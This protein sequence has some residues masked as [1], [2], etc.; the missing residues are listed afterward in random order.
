MKKMK[1][2]IMCVLMLSFSNVN[3]Q[4]RNFIVSGIERFF[5]QADGVAIVGLGMANLP[6]D[7]CSFFTYHFK[8]DSTTEAGKNLLSVVMTAKISKSRTSV[9]YF[10]S[11]AVGKDETN[12]CG[13]NSLSVLD[14][15]GLS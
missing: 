14:A 8:F 5:V 4:S 10:P 2:L 12:G 11:S 1:V 3:A 15:V 13:I 6:K 9:W 7:T